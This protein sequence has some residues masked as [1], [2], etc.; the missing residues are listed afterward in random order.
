L[1]LMKLLAYSKVWKWGCSLIES[2][3]RLFFA[4]NIPHK[5]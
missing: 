2:G 3:T 1:S 4:S 5:Y